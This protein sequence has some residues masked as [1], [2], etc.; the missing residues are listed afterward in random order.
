MKA[1]QPIS[2]KEAA[3]RKFMEF[4]KDEMRVLSRRSNG[5]PKINRLPPSEGFIDMWVT[6]NRSALRR[7]LNGQK[8]TQTI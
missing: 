5:K 2:D 8:G 7:L 1:I 3:Y 4:T 6:A